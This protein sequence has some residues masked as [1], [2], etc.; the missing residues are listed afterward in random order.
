MIKQAPLMWI[1]GEPFPFPSRDF[2]FVSSQLV[3]GGR[4]ENGVVTIQKINRRMAKFDSLVFPYLSATEWRFIRQKIEQMVVNITYYDDYEDRVLTRK[5]YFGDS[6]AQIW[7]LD[8][9]TYDTENYTTMVVQ[10]PKSYIN[11]TVNIIDMG[12]DEVTV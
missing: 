9:A 10:K 1:D 7:E 12:E 8:G 6:S 4:N 2:K 11:C 5:F 3:S